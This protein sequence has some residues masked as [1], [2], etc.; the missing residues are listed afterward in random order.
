MEIL[1][2]CS[3]VVASTCRRTSDDLVSGDLPPFP[4][5]DG[6]LEPIRITPFLPMQLPA[7][8]ML[9]EML[10]M[11]RTASAYEVSDEPW[12]RIEQLI[13]KR[14]NTQPFGGGK[15]QKP[16]QICMNAMWIRRCWPNLWHLHWDWQNRVAIMLNDR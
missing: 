15:L 3:P 5:S 11:A 10:R 12:E 13:P 6:H 4:K 7:S 14:M 8:R 9:A 1:G 16:H 2:T